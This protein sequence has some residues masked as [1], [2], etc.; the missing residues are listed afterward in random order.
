MLAKGNMRKGVGRLWRLAIQKQRRTGWISLN[1]E[2]RDLLDL[3]ECK[4]S[5]ANPLCDCSADVFNCDIVL[6]CGAQ[7]MLAKGNMRKGV[8][9]LWRLAIQKQRRT[10]WISLYRERCDFLDL[11]ECQTNFG[12]HPPAY[13]NVLL[14][15]LIRSEERR[16]VKECRCRR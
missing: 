3:S 2:R 9:R 4:R 12:N 13:L 7:L 16:E 10:G 1:R 8:G 14:N 6:Q 15:R 11:S 5:H